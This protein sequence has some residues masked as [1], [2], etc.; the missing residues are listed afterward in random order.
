LS[1][2]ATVELCRKV[3]YE[4]F[5]EGAPCV[6]QDQ[7]S[8]YLYVVLSGQVGLYYKPSRRLLAA[9]HQPNAT[10]GSSRGGLS[11]SH[12]SRVE[13]P[14]EPQIG[15]QFMTKSDPALGTLLQVVRVGQ[16]LDELSPFS[17][18][19]GASPSKARPFS[20][21]SAKALTPLELVRIPM[22]LMLTP[23]IL[24]ELSR[25]P[26]ILQPHNFKQILRRSAH[27]R[28]NYEHA[29]VAK[30]LRASDLDDEV[31]SQSALNKLAKLVRYIE[32]EPQSVVYEAGEVA[33]A[34]YI[35]LDGVFE[36]YSMLKA[37]RR[38]AVRSSANHDAQ[39]ASFGTL[40]AVVGPLGTVGE[41]ELIASRPRTDTCLAKTKVLALRISREAYV[42]I[43]LHARQ[44][45][46][47][48]RT[49]LL[50]ASGA[51]E[52]NA[53][54]TKLASIAKRARFERGEVMVR[55]GGAI[56]SVMLIEQGT[57]ALSRLFKM[58]QAPME[59][60]LGVAS[61]SCTEYDLHSNCTIG[62]CSR[63]HIRSET[64]I[65]LCPKSSPEFVGNLVSRL[66]SEAQQDRLA[67]GREPARA[68][69]SLDL[70]YVSHNTWLGLE[71]A[72]V[73]T[74]YD[75]NNLKG[76]QES[77]VFGSE[78]VVTAVAVTAMDVL[79]FPRKELGKCGQE[80]LLWFMKR[81]LDVS[82]DRLK[83]GKQRLDQRNKLAIRQLLPVSAGDSRASGSGTLS[84]FF[85]MISTK[86][87][88]AP[89]AG[90]WNTPKWQGLPTLEPGDKPRPDPAAA[91]I[92]NVRHMHRRMF[93]ARFQAGTTA[94]V[95]Y[96]IHRA[97]T[98]AADRRRF[99]AVR[100]T[101]EQKK[102]RHEASWSSDSPASQEPDGDD[103][104]SD[105]DDSSCS[106]SAQ[107]STPAPFAEALPEHDAATVAK[108]T[109]D[110]SD[111]H[112]LR[113]Y[114]RFALL[115]ANGRELLDR[116][117][118]MPF[119]SLRSRTAALNDLCSF[120]WCLAIRRSGGSILEMLQSADTDGSLSCICIYAFLGVQALRG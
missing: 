50:H 52:S 46:L 119:L 20:A 105:S 117:P 18:T 45:Q 13:R 32:V 79:L 23:I 33:T 24:S 82:D 34:M 17:V 118:E 96:I 89:E 80:L 93:A 90:K 68:A 111:R 85:T 72:K 115:D 7:P 108:P 102:L 61:R 42:T 5:A 91:N 8:E 120:R 59:Q 94:N 27:Y 81:G 98:K 95:D 110:P 100:T 16:A 39:L 63:R 57:C 84:Q 29:E 86:P 19:P 22:A 31:L 36:M 26:P 37:D 103:P 15:E 101:A 109:L 54:L 51:P 58:S 97:E 66:F 14:A 38:G 9:S 113:F 47:R 71:M 43:L 106:G 99:H 78:S 92:R 74:G 55:E 76:C 40:T 28:H 62:F 25:N 114:E 48:A 75:R 60:W 49:K 69:Q 88:A 112:L 21:V 10:L 104:S 77:D 30:L 11:L 2:F 116:W 35:V 87:D 4:A 67:G 12:Q 107:T 6:Y 65:A 3:E 73:L 53:T 83:Q 41:A 1:E 70:V 44:K 56:D 64:G